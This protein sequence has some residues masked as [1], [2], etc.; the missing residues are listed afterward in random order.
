[1]ASHNITL[2]QTRVG[3]RIKTQVH[4]GPD[5]D[6][7]QLAGTLVLSVGETQVFG[8]AL[9]AGARLMVGAL[10]VKTPDDAVI[11]PMEA[12]IDV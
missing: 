2:R 3:E 10:S 8:A 1:M 5:A 11:F 4:I 12:A 7:M 6:H 9:Y